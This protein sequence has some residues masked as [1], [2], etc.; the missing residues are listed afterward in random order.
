[1]WHWKDKYF[2]DGW[3]IFDQAMYFVLV[4]AI[5][6]RFTLTSESDFVWARNVYAV[7]LVMF[8][9]RILEIFL[10]HRHIGPTIVMIGRM[11]R[12]VISDI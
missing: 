7:N 8:Y 1:M 6:L 12:S 5:V 3:N 10:I 4:L 2:T 11:V 9:L